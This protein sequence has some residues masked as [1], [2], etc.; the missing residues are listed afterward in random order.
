MSSRRL[1]VVLILAA[2][3]LSLPAAAT[4]GDWFACFRRPQPGAAKAPYT[5]PPV[6]V[7][8]PPGPY[9]CPAYANGNYPWYGYGFGVPTY[10]WGYCG[11]TFR[12]VEFCHFGYYNQYSQVGYQRGY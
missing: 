5:P 11:S 12:P 10:Q 9:R 8:A 6:V 2:V 4:A 3:T 7:G 1:L